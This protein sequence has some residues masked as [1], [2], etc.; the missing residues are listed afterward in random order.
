MVISSSN[1]VKYFLWLNNWFAD[2]WSAGPMILEKC[3]ETWETG[4][5]SQTGS[6]LKHVDDLFGVV[7]RGVMSLQKRNLC[8]VCIYMDCPA[9]CHVFVCYR[10]WSAVIIHGTSTALQ[11]KPEP[12]DCCSCNYKNLLSKQRHGRDR[13][14]RRESGKEKEEWE[15][16]WAATKLCIVLDQTHTHTRTQATQLTNTSLS[17]G[18][19]KSNCDLCL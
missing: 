19:Y 16:A 8:I 14:Q 1:E 4:R 12:T 18:S 7:P 6:L 11:A 3:W 9:F 2:I 10:C 15:R 5:S 13:G 17:S